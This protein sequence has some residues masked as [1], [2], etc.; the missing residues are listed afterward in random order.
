[1]SA[2]TMTVG[3]AIE[4]LSKFYRADRLT[5]F[6]PKWQWGNNCF[7]EEIKKNRLPQGINQ[8]E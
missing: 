6:V 3:E 1:M 8:S 7:I 5:V 4:A 2:S